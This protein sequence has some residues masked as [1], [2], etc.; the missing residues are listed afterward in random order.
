MKGNNIILLLQV[1]AFLPGFLLDLIF[2][3]WIYFGLGVWSMII[4][5]VTPFFYEEWKA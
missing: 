3:D 1:L 2:V 4:A 5:T